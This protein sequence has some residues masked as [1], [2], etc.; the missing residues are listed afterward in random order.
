MVTGDLLMAARA[1][2]EESFRA[3]V[4]PHRRELHVHC[5][6]MLGSVQDAEDMVQETLMAAW[7]GFEAYEGRASVRSWLYRIA[8]NRCLNALRDGTRRPRKADPFGTTP[9]PPTRLVEPAWLEPYPDSLLDGVPDTSPGPEARVESREAIS[10][11]FV[12]AMQSLPP[13]QRAVLLLRDVLGFR[14]AEVA[15]MLDTTPESVTSA[16]K[17]ARAVL[18][19]ERPARTPGAAERA[20]ATAFADAMERGDVPA[21]VA[22]LSD[23]AWLT[24]PPGPQ[25][26]HGPQLIGQF[27]QMVVFR[28]GARRY[29]LIPT[30]ANR[31]P[32][33]GLYGYDHGEPVGHLRGVLVLTLEGDRISAITRFDNSTMPYFGLPD[34]LPSD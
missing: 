29:R 15:R 7:R 20:L 16:L 24:M 6:R 3:L 12:T 28:R 25:Q 2:D 5:Y 21:M 31:Q 13:R 14:A 34:T 19:H 33:F 27:M 11:A 4:E 18:P 30:A 10:L 9:P 22:L 17:R 1:G 26:Y 32:A 23:D 8:T